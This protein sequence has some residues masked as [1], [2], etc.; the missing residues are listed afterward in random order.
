MAKHPL[1]VIME[2]DP[3]LF[4]ALSDAGKLALSDG[5]LPAKT[6]LLIAMAL[7]AAHGAADGVKALATQAL[8]NGATKEEVLEAV[9]VAY[10]VC[11]AGSVYTAARGLDGVFGQE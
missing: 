1:S 8:A 10:H 7:D 5:A 11:G 2:H 4:A 6:K 3:A 9:R